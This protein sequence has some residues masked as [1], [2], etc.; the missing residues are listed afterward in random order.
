MGMF[1]ARSWSSL[2]FRRV[3]AASCRAWGSCRGGFPGLLV[4]VGES[5]LQLSLGPLSAGLEGG[6]GV[7][8][9]RRSGARRPSPP[10][11]ARR[12]R[13]P[14]PLLPR[15]FLAATAS[16]SAAALPPAPRPAAHRPAA[17]PH[18]PAQPRPRRVRRGPG[19]PRGPPGPPRSAPR[20]R[21]QPGLVP[22]GVLA[23]LP[24]CRSAATRA[25]VQ[26]RASRLRRL[27]RP[28][29]ILLGLPGPGLAAPATASSHSCCAAATCSSRPA[30]PGSPCLRGRGL[31]FGRGLASQ[32][33]GQP[34][35]GLQRGRARLRGLGLGPL[36]ALRASA[37]PEREP[38]AARLRRPGRPATLPGQHLTPPERGQRRM[39]LA[40]HRVGQPAVPRLR[41][42]PGLPRPRLIR[43]AGIRAP[44][45]LLSGV[46]HRQAPF[47]SMT[48]PNRA[49]P[50]ARNRCILA[51]G[52]HPAGQRQ[53]GWPGT[54]AGRTGS[55]PSQAR[56]YHRPLVMIGR[57][58]IR[59]PLRLRPELVVMALGCQRPGPGPG[60]LGAP[61]RPPG[62]RR[63]GCRRLPRT[64]H[65]ARN[66]RSAT[67]RP[68][69][70]GPVQPAME[71]RRGQHRVPELGV[72]PAAERGLG[73]EPLA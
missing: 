17:R 33:L 39:R 57:H 55:Q 14:A 12:P 43:A 24:T 41:R 50:G 42:L 45:D 26:L 2:S 73:Q 48:K 11:P 9:R 10:G 65:T 37:S 47:R 54:C 67:R 16:C 44:G 62:W 15:G 6:A 3:P 72:P 59:G 52:D 46:G 8:S 18:A 71:G 28:G 20:R 51:T 23:D 49:T 56:S 22:R 38:R 69:P 61:G 68:P 32:R 66:R 36:A 1:C 4:A 60:V 5:T 58:I 21:P 29:R 25:P 70:A 40:G 19:G 27:P 13:G 34:R 7:L 63:R 31:L 35:I 30:G 64:G 53:G